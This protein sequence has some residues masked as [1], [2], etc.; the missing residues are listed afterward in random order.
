MHTFI[1]IF[2]YTDR[3]YRAEFKKQC[4]EMGKGKGLMGG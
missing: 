1:T 4:E 2:A 3:K